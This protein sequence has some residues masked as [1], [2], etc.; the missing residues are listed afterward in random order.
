[1]S[2]VATAAFAANRT[3]PQIKVAVHF[4]ATRFGKATEE[5]WKKIM[6]VMAYLNGIKS[7]QK[8]VLD[9]VSVDK[10][11]ATADSAYAIDVNCKSTS[12]GCIG[13]PGANG[14]TSYFL[15]I[16]KT[17]PIVTRSSSEAELVAASYVTEYGLWVTYMLEELGF[18]K[19]IIELEQDNTSSIS[20]VKRG[21]GTFSR[22]KHIKVRWF[23]IAML[24]EDGELTVEH[25]PTD[26]M[27]ADIL[28]KPL[29]F[30]AHWLETGD[31]LSWT[32]TSNFV[33]STRSRI[34]QIYS[35]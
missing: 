9:A 33:W 28:S 15:W 10:V 5:D 12:A 31:K 32:R 23:W 13:F 6:R 4:C 24:I 17:Q 35:P 19:R 1:M 27:T 25:V 22:T 29:A 34:C 3:V 16:H 11:I 8:V 26:Q 21:R 2:A 20:F 30:Q 7:V 14:K 18:G